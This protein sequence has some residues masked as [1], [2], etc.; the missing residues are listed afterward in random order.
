MP[1]ASVLLQEIVMRG[2]NSDTPVGALPSGSLL[3]WD[4]IFPWKVH[5]TDI[6]A[7]GHCTTDRKVLLVRVL[8]GAA[9]LPFNQ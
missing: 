3:T 2:E 9:V 6:R 7:L 4:Q 1:A 8:T 5:G